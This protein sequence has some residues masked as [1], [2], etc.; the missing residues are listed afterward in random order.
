MGRV[1]IA[2]VVVGAGAGKAVSIFEHGTTTVP[3]L[4]PEATGSATVA[5]LLTNK[6]GYYGCWVDEGRYDLILPYSPLQKHTVDAI[7]QGTVAALTTAG[8]A[9]VQLAARAVSV[10]NLTL[11]GTKAAD[12]TDG[13]TMETGDILLCTGQNDATEN[14]LWV[15]GTWQRP[16]GFTGVVA[17]GYTVFIYDGE[18]HRGSIYGLIS[19][20][21]PLTVGTDELAWEENTIGSKAAAEQTPVIPFAPGTYANLEDWPSLALPGRPDM[22][23]WRADQLAAHARS[24]QMVAAIK[25]GAANKI[26]TT[27]ATEYGPEDFLPVMNLGRSTDPAVDYGD[28]FTYWPKVHTPAGAPTSK[29]S[30]DK[31]VLDI[32][33]LT[34]RGVTIGASTVSGHDLRNGPGISANSKAVSEGGSEIP[35]AGEALVSDT[36]TTGKVTTTNGSDT[37]SMPITGTIKVG[38]TLSGNAAIPAGTKVK[39]VKTTELVL[40]EKATESKSNVDTTFTGKHATNEAGGPS[41]SRIEANAF[42]TVR[43]RNLYD[44]DLNWRTAINHTLR[45]TVRG[46]A[47]KAGAPSGAGMAARAIS[48]FG[49]GMDLEPDDNR[50]P[51]IWPATQG[52]QTG[53]ASTNPDAPPNGALLAFDPATF[54]DSYIANLACPNW[55]KAVYHAMV[56]WGSLVV[57]VQGQEGVEL[58]RFESLF[59]YKWRSSYYIDWLK[60]HTDGKWLVEEKEPFPNEAFKRWKF[61]ITGAGTM[62]STIFGALVVRKPPP[63]PEDIAALLP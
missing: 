47:A 13:V 44:A 42:L 18:V 22:F 45:T 49:E 58:C 26:S 17:N 23:R 30:S 54:T 61:D 43:A 32:D 9:P 46:P 35:M 37:V 16:E 4:Y 1:N 3:T 53:N 2:G 62:T 24:A 20:A 15:Y 25:E 31:G 51:S 56:F 52:E 10:T 12:E 34:G 36:V 40:T 38:M 6:S 48:L 60:A 5:S 55:V 57:D 14:G 19:T 8:V 59:S 27:K 41:S 29:A 7:D 11:S 63:I 21:K 50:L 33:A 28:I 39:E